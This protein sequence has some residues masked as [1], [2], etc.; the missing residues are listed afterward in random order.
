[1]IMLKFDTIVLKMDWP[2]YRDG[3]RFCYPKVTSEL[4][5]V[6][7]LRSE[8]YGINFILQNVITYMYNHKKNNA[9]FQAMKTKQLL[10]KRF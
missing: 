1:M 5:R 7:L 9:K 3:T 10:I 6:A 4:L 2:V 8:L